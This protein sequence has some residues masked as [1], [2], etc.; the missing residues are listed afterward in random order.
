MPV[1]KT[2]EKRK[3]LQCCVCLTGQHREM[4]KQVMDAFHIQEDYNLNIMKQGQT[5]TSVTVDILGALGEIIQ[6]EKPG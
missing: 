6:K 4:L 3:K 2:A 5:L 1:D